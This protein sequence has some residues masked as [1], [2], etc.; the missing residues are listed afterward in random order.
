[1]RNAGHIVW[2][3]IGVGAVAAAIGIYSAS[4][5]ELIRLT[6]R[7][8]Q[9]A[10]PLLALSE[11]RRQ[12]AL[13]AYGKLPLTFVENRGQTDRRVRYYAQRG[14]FAVYFTPGEVVF[15]FG[16]PSPATASTAA[17]RFRPP[18]IPAALS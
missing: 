14:N 9:R 12:Q 1:M 18:V 13:T 5:A 10:R 6:H 16:K 7:Q 17:G 8:N 4:Q 2:A 11:D 3:A 15:A